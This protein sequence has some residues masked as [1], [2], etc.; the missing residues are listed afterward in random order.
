MIT[1]YIDSITGETKT[2]EEWSQVVLDCGQ[3]LASAI[4]LVDEDIVSNELVE[5]YLTK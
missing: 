2:R 4:Q 3:D 5:K 1:M